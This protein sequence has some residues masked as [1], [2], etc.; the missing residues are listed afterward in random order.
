MTQEPRED[1]GQVPWQFGVVSACRLPRHLQQKE[2]LAA[3][4]LIRIQVQRHA[5]RHT[6]TR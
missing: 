5:V 1:M 4:N 3:A 2:Q 6:C